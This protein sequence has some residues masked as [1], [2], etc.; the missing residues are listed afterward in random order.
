MAE[1]IVTLVL[2]LGGLVY[3]LL[4]HQLAFGTLASPKSGFLPVLAGTVAVLLALALVVRQWRSHQWVPQSQVNWT[5][6]SFIIIGLIFYV[7]ILRIIGFFAATFVFLFYLFKV[8]D[9][10]GWAVPF[11]IAAASA[12][13]F[14]LLFERYLVVTLP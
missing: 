4:A 11:M 8:A 5:T 1:K 10:P 7:A 12:T 3:L 6:F 2:L 9:T 14:Y 13:V